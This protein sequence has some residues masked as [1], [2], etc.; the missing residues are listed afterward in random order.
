MK[1]TKKTII[2][3]A[4]LLAIALGGVIYTHSW[5]NYHTRF[6]SLTQGGHH[7]PPLVDTH[8]LVMAQQ[9]APLAATSM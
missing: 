5:A 8:A 3:L 7:A 2:G 9:L 6:R 1:G 4:V